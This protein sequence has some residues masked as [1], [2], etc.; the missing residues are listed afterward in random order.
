M[1]LIGDHEYTI[2]SRMNLKI[3]PGKLFIIKITSFKGFKEFSPSEW[4]ENCVIWA[5]SGSV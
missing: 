1:I 5:L 4:I 3:V 2:N